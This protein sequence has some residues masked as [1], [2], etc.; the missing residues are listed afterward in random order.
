MKL[1]QKL[2]AIQKD[3]ATQV[4]A[5]ILAAFGES[6]QSLMASN[7]ADKALK[8]GDM[9]PNFEIELDGKMTDLASLLENGTVVLN[10]FRGNWCPFCMAELE[11]YQTLFSESAKEMNASQ[12]LFIS[13]QKKRFN[14]QLKEA[15]GLNH[16]F[17]T[18]AD[19]EKAQKFGLV[20]QLESSIQEIYK[21]IGA[22][23]NE[24]NGDD[25]FKL[26]IPATYII[27]PT[28]KISY[29]FVDANYMMRAEPKIVL[30]I[31]A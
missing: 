31:I 9:A 17:V 6:L 5:E 22:D 2:Q 30:P 23:L 18:D 11:A 13:P 15:Q 8:V 28:G 21:A 4:P 19:N 14:D 26:P 1:E 16:Q 25:S 27:E 3:L 29:A 24:F 20:F 10:F 7:I 12:F